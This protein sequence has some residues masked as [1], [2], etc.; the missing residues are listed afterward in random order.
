[1]TINIRPAKAEDADAIAT[2]HINSW[3]ETYRGLLPDELLDGLRQDERA[4]LWSKIIAANGHYPTNAQFVADSAG[5]IVGFGSCGLGRSKECVAAGYKGE[6][7]TLYVLKPFQNYGLGSAIF[8]R[9]AKHL[10]GTGVDAASLWVLGTNIHAR[11]FYERHGGVAFK[12]R[13][14]NHR[15]C[16]T[17]EIAY[18]WSHLPK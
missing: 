9:I 5:E 16:S 17:T 12:E 3:R 2:V 6:I 10:V 18:G 7:S 1:M 8:H 14:D 13:T 15:G 4:E 11:K